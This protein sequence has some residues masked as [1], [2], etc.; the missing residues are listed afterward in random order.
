MG[1]PEGLALGAATCDREAHYLCFAAMHG[2]VWF[3]V[4]P[5]RSSK[6]ST[7]GVQQ[8]SRPKSQ[9]QPPSRRSDQQPVSKVHVLILVCSDGIPSHGRWP[10]LLGQ[11]VSRLQ[12]G[13]Q[14]SWAQAAAVRIH[15]PSLQLLPLTSAAWRALR[16]PQA[17]AWP[18]HLHSVQGIQHSRTFVVHLGELVWLWPEARLGHDPAASSYS[19]VSICLSAGGSCTAV[20]TAAS[21][22]VRA[23]PPHTV[24]KTQ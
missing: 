9:D 15:R 24:R 1:L 4:G 23:I 2:R 22:C 19:R 12:E 14:P 8:A 10:Q 21:N 11:L 17:L 6:E 5:S 20:P 3:K 18:L 7:L 16:Q 13:P